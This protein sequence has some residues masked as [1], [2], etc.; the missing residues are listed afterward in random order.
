LSD[1]FKCVEGE[2]VP[3]ARGP[4]STAVVWENLVF[5]SGL[6]AVKAD[7]DTVNGGVRE[8]T[9]VILRNLKNVLEAAGSGLEKVLS[10]TVYLADIGNLTAFNEVYEELF[11]PP[12]P[13]R[14][15]A[16]VSLPAGFLVE[17]SAVA[18]K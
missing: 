8:E 1:G 16:G 6:L 13:A 4:Y 11:Q 15:T 9:M 5:V 7:G 10:V 18:F 3:P 2:A 17:L 12:Y 14:A